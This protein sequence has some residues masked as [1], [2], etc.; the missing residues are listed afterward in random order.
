MAKKKTF[1]AE[2]ERLS[3]A[4]PDSRFATLRR[5][6]KDPGNKVVVSLGGGALAGL[7]GNLAIWRILEEL[8]LAHEV[9]E[10]WG[11]SAGAVIAGGWASGAKAHDVLDRV[12]GLGEKGAVDVSMTRFVLRML[13]SLWPFRRPLPNG[14]V[15][16]Q[17]FRDTIEGG[18][19]AKTFE[20]CKIPLRCVV[21]TDRGRPQARVLQR[22][23]LL[24]AIYAS[25]SLPGIMV[26]IPIDG[27]TYYDG[28]L[29]EKTPRRSILADHGRSSDDRKLVVIATHFINSADDEPA[30]SFLARLLHSLYALEDTLWGY[31][32][33]EA[34]EKDD[35]TLLLLDPHIEE[36]ALFA[37]ENTV[38]H[39]LTARTRFANDLQ[40]S[41]IISTLGTG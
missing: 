11:T 41:R 28:G 21:C 31:Q 32:L 40:D 6:V 22:G 14:V 27:V 24:P 36:P 7:C 17:R 33:A 10:I 25:M 13:A 4:L 29:V 2:A 19:R 12:G 8:E 23:E 26:P 3:D 30:Q 38:K 16:G 1:A 18:L 34:R 39:Y 15:R 35:L 9:D 20:E 5:L 37:F